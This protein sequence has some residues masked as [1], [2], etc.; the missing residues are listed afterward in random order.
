MKLVAIHPA[1]QTEFREIVEYY[2]AIDTEL[3]D[4]FVNC[5]ISCRNKIAKSPEHYRIRRGVTRR[6]NLLPR[7]EEYYLP[8][9]I[10]QDKVV[11]LAVAHAKRR[12]YY[13][14]N[15]IGEAKKMFE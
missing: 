7:F 4:A 2:D 14:R 9:M 13:W 8:F 5:F 11:I 1:A 15:R 12:P 10:W 3:A 6:V